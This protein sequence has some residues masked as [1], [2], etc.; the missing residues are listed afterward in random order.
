M[1]V[2]SLKVT[3]QIDGLNNEFTQLIDIDQND[4]DTLIG[5]ALNRL[6]EYQDC[7]ASINDKGRFKCNAPMIIDIELEGTLISTEDI[8]NPKSKEGLKIGN[9]AKGKKRFA[10]KMY[11][12]L[13][14]AHSMPK[15]V[16]YSKVIDGLDAQ[17]ALIDAQK[18]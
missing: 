10:Q 15:Q 12:L 16:K 5:T 3:Q 14:F 4:F 18:A 13:T 2:L 9:T 17:I 6:F 11:R 7:L 8:L 1:Q